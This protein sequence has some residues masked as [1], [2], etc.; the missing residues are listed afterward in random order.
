VVSHGKDCDSEEPLDVHELE[1]VGDANS[2][3]SHQGFRQYTVNVSSRHTDRNYNTELANNMPP[4]D[5][6]ARAYTNCA[7][8]FFAALLITWV[9]HLFIIEISG[10]LIARSHQPLTG[11]TP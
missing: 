2:P 1:P 8:L 5:A 9:S 10:N 11:F 6:A 7:L 3:T 4:S